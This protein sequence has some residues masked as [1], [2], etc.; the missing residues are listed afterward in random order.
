[1]ANQ[2][3]ESAAAD[4]SDRAPVAR[5]RPAPRIF[6]TPKQEQTLARVTSG[7]TSQQPALSASMNA[8]A[9][10]S[11]A[12]KTLTP[13]ANTLSTAANTTDRGGADARR[14]RTP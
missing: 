8:M 13:A 7:M 12:A 1:M 5:C 14:A 4:V 10:M 11:A 3:R 6:P 2:A 9:P